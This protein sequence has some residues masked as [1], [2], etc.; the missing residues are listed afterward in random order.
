MAM[1][2]TLDDCLREGGAIPSKPSQPDDAIRPLG[3]TT[4]D[5]HTP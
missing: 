4:R 5:L 1:S 3:R 2:T